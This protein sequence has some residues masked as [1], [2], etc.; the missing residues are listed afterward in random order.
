MLRYQGENNCVDFPGNSEDKTGYGCEV[1]NLITL[2]TLQILSV[3][4]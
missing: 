2:T 3:F 4:G 1:V